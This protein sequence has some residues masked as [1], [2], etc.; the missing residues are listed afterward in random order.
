MA[1][2]SDASFSVEVSGTAPLSYRWFKNGAPIAGADEPVL[3]LASVRA[4]NAGSYS[5]TVENAAG[6][7][8]S[9]EAVLQVSG[10]ESSCAESGDAG[11]EYQVYLPFIQR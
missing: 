8:S 7:V 9:Q 2:C 4:V 1:A 5:V 11:D 6:E 3:E 10:D